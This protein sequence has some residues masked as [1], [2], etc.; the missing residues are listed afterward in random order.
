MRTIKVKIVLITVIC[1]AVS[2][3]ICGGFNLYQSASISSEDAGEMLVMHSSSVSQE[4]DSTLSGIEQSVDTLAQIA[5]QSLTDVN[6]FRTDASYVESYTNQIRPIALEFANNTEG[7]L[8]YY[9]R[10]NPD[11]TSPTSGIFAS[12]NSDSAS[13][14]QL[15]PT[16]FSIY[17]KN[18]AAHV[19]WYY[20]PV[21][22]GKATWMDP[23]LNSNI[24]VYMISYVVPIYVNNV[25]IGVVG[26]DI[27]FG[28]LQ[29][30]T[31]NVKLYETGGAFL[32]NSDSKIM[33]HSSLEVG[34]DLTTYNDSGIKPLVDALANSQNE[35][36]CIDYSYNGT[37]KTGTYNSLRNGMKVV[38]SVP[39]SE[40]ESQLSQILGTTLLAE[41]VSIVFSALVGFFL[42]NGI[43]SPIKKMTLV[44]QDIA[45]L[46]LKKNQDISK[47]TKMKDE[48]GA[49]AR[50]VQT[51]NDSLYKMVGYIGQTGDLISANAEKLKASSGSVSE[52]CSDNSATT[53]ELAAAMQEFSATSSVVSQNIGTVNENAKSIMELSRKG[54][55]DSVQILERAN[56]LSRKTQNATNRTNDMYKQVRRQTD[57]ALERAKAVEKIK[58]LTNNI[59]EISSQTNLLALNASIEAAR[60]GEAGRG[61]AVV[62]DEIGNLSVQTKDSVKDIETIIEEVYS[63]VN[64]MGECLNAST[65]FLENTVLEDY[66]EFMNVSEQYAQDANNFRSNMSMIDE[67][68]ES[69]GK[70]ISDIANVMEGMSVRTNEAA[71][72]ISAIAEKTASI[73]EKMA[74]EGDMVMQNRNNA[75]ELEK[76][77]EQF[78]LEE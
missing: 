38:L 74:D 60:A 39:Q 34:T 48:T 8:T 64:N 69:L 3:L 9:I 76:V 49:M 42:S 16:D 55:E 53:Q 65:E 56:N 72:G 40:I 14:T 32:T 71:Q 52:M 73:V 30:I 59:L 6:R 27:D 5:Q 26:M 66:N 7:A 50:A 57:E 51:M 67:A 28:K 70:A 25:S 31:E 18:D 22:N 35:G 2:T 4:I 10:Y 37:K 62:A 46:N 12:R 75:N 63:S 24:N 54:G 36:Q 61:F 68:I 19:G 11:F 45:Q 20:I 21:Q 15:T 23:Y 78:T 17:D 43:A 47:L 58:E 13:F 44:V 41:L 1:A 33:Y 29:S 77:V